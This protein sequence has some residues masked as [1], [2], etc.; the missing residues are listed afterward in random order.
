MNLR[1]IIVDFNHRIEQAVSAARLATYVA[2]ASSMERARALYRWN[3]ELSAALAPLISDL[4]VT[5]RNTI[6]DRLSAHFGRSDWWAASALQ[7]DDITSDLLTEVV[8][9]HQKKIAK[10]TVG[11]G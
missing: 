9:R 8:Q 6:H 2:Q 1:S 7:L 11:P 4:E 5:L 10:G 3:I